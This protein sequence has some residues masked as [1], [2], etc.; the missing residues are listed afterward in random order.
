MTIP[1]EKRRL[2]KFFQTEYLKLLGFVRRRVDEIAAQDAEDFVHDIALQLFDRSDIA[3]PIE[4]LSA[5]VYRA[6][7]NRITD[8][9]RKRTRISHQRSPEQDRELEN[10]ADVVEE[11]GYDSAPEMRR[12]EIAHDLFRL[13]EELNEEEKRLIIANDIQGLTIGHLS[14]SW[15]V[16]VNTLLSRKSRALKKIQRQI[17]NKQKVKE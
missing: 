9:F 2:A 4:H 17:Q 12:V 14:K 8:Y 7:Q 1:S 5:Y 13:L 16:P 3:L 11:T 10:L 6:L 15:A